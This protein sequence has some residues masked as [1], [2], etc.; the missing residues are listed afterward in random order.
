[1]E[2]ILKLM[3]SFVARSLINLSGLCFRV[4][5]CYSFESETNGAECNKRVNPIST[6]RNF[7]EEVSTSKIFSRE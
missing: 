7:R 1:M 5:L 3:I 4:S 2:C 6:I